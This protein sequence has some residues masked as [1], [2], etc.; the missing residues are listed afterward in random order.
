MSTAIAATG[1]SQEA[2]DAFLAARDEPAWLDRY[3][4]QGLAA[5]SR[6][7]DAVGPRRRVDADRYSAV[8]ARSVRSAGCAVRS[9]AAA[10]FAHPHA[11]LAAGVEL[12]RPRGEHE[13]PFGIGRAR[14]EVG[15][16]RACC[17]AA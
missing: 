8:Q 15:R 1:F 9:E 11:L 14:A 6:I 17:S 5:V 16:S 4:P 12:G 10:E 3:A 7:A 2:F 13:Q